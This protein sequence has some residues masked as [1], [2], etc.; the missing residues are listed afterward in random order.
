MQTQTRFVTKCNRD[1]AQSL[2][3][4]QHYHGKEAENGVDITILRRLHKKLIRRGT[5]TGTDMLYKLV[6]TQIYDVPRV[7]EYNAAEAA[8]VT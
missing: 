6:T 2:E 8:Q 3:A 5:Y 4:A 1:P 7:C